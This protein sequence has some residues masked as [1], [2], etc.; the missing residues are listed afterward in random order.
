M[1]TRSHITFGSSLLFVCTL[2]AA[3]ALTACQGRV[4]PTVESLG[5]TAIP[6][7]IATNTAPPPTTTPTYTRAATSTATLTRTP[8]STFTSTSTQTPTATPTATPL[9]LQR[10]DNILILGIDHRPYDADP[11][12]RTDTLM[13]AAIDWKTEQIGF[14]S[15]PRDLYVDIPGLGK[16]RI[17]V[18]DYYGVA[19]KYPGGGPALVRQVIS[20]TL[21]IPAQHYVRVQM[22]GLVRLV[23]ALGGVTVTLDC[24]LYE[25]APDETSPNGVV[26]WNLPAGKVFLN[27]ENA[28]KFATYRYVNTDFGRA[29]RQQQLIWAI[30][31]RAL[32]LDVIPRIPELWKALADTFNTDLTLLDVVKLAKLGLTLKPEKVRGLVFSTD[33]IDY[34]VTEEG[35]WV[36]VIKDQEKLKAEQ[37]RLF[38]SQPLAQWGKAEPGKCPPPPTEVPTFTPTPKPDPNATPTPK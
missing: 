20:D 29:Q 3:T 33:V 30:R 34:Y 19:T 36:L 7:Q 8:T 13:I 35:A 25:R 9:L 37:Q 23:D 24:P 11:S 12:W 2:F 4:G 16:E 6:T 10:T 15:I 18:A 1:K 32:Q 27:G 28:K 5:T 31:D 26:D 14:V 22:D 17:N 38:E 21:G